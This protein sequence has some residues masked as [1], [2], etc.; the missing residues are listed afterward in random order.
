MRQ[1]RGYVEMRNAGDFLPE[2]VIQM[3]QKQHYGL[4]GH[5]AVKLCHYTKTSIKGKEKCY[6][7]KFYGIQSQ[8][9]LQ[10]TPTSSFCDQ[11]CIYCWRPI[12]AQETKLK[13]VENPEDII[14]N[15]L[16]EQEKLLS[17]F[18]SLVKQGLVSKKMLEQALK[19]RH[20]AISLSGE[21]TLYSKLPELIKGFHKRRISTFLVSNGLHPEMLAKLIRKKAKPTQL[22]LSVDSGVKEVH[23]RLNRPAVKDSWKR[24]Q[25]SLS[26]LKK[27]PRTCIRVTL[28]KGWNDNHEK[29]LAELIEKARPSFAEIKAYMFV[30]Y[31]RQRL[32]QEN[33]PLH[34]EVKAFAKKLLK[35]LKHYKLQDDDS[36]SRVVL[37]W[38]GKTKLKIDFGKIGK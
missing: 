27:F 10:M 21:P 33:M 14:E 30:G 31:S 28:V 35:N 16:K 8:L 7:H 4:F 5:S 29:E 18:G 26:L 20:A 9:C 19:P 36:L 32:K 1:K 37:L 34:S 13:S 12:T 3:L 25:K 11:K 38:N 15:A 22:Y 24:I 17:G 6:K 2:S 23:E